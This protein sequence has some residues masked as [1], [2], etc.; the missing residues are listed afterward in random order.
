MAT[1]VILIMAAVLTFLA[2]GLA[3]AAMAGGSFGLV[4]GIDVETILYAFLKKKE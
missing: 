3:I 1:F 2:L 4:S